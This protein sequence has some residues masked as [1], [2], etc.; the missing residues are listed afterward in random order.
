MARS[1]KPPRPARRGRATRVRAA[2]SPGGRGKHVVYVHGICRHDPGYS[3]A[4][5]A[6]MKP[7]VPDVPDP[8]HH[9]VLWSD[10]ITAAA[11]ASPAAALAAAQALLHPAAAGTQSEVALDIKE[12]LADRAQRQLVEASLRTAVVPAAGPAAP[13]AALTFQAPGLRAFFDIPGLE[14]IDDFARY[15]LDDA[16]RGQVIGRFNDVVEPLLA[17][18]ALVEVI[19]HSWG[20]VV[21]YEAL[22]G[23]DDRTGLPD[24]SVAT[25]FTVG[26]A[27]AIPPVKRRLLPAAVDG[28]RPRVVRTWVNLNAEFDIV[29]GHL[30]GNP[31]AVDDEYLGL[32]PVGCSA[33]IPN[34]ACAHGS[35]FRPDNV[36]VNRDILGRYIQA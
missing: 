1:R 6:A 13:R 12:V 10:L 17:G 34:P 16:T 27:L 15:L 25:L 21:A 18:G 23:M 36:L 22:R 3:D 2:S 33:V 29:G 31:F 7:F 28:R 32:P 20:T 35:Y 24:G 5:W 9:E 11:P 8:N 30:R 14:C 19:S 4:W 26:S